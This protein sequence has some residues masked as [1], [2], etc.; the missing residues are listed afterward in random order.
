MTQP[1]A[2]TQILTGFLTRLGPPLQPVPN[3]NGT[4]KG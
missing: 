4:L 3:T 1:V 2:V